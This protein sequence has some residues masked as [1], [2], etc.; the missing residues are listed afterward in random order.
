MF[1]DDYG[2]GSICLNSFCDN[3]YE[4]DMELLEFVLE[5]VRTGEYEAVDAVLSSVYE[6]EKGMYIEGNMVPAGSRLSPPL[7]R[8]GIR[9]NR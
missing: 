5:T 9:D 2:Q 3:F 4:D 8:S 6:D 1:F 7:K